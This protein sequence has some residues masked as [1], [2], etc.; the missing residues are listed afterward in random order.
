VH[1]EHRQLLLSQQVGD[2]LVQGMEALAPVDHEDQEI[3]AI[4]CR[5]RLA[6]DRTLE[7]ALRILNDPT[8]IDDVEASARPVGVGEVDVP[9]DPG[10][11][12][13]D[14]PPAPDDPVEERR[15]THV[16]AADDGHRGRVGPCRVL[17]PSGLGVA[18]RLGR[19]CRRRCVFH[20]VMG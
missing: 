4:Q 20:L 16:G 11:A 12:V 14:C 18:R 6:P 8:R 2:V 19:D 3:G 17:T 13:D 9:R 5:Q 7:L 15:L 10:L 1:Q